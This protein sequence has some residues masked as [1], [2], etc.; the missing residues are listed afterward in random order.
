MIKSEIK[1]LPKSKIELSISVSWDGWKENIDEAVKKISQEIKIPGF[2][3]GKAPRKLIEEKVGSNVV[4]DEAAQLTIAKTY[5]EVLKKDKIEAIGQPKAEILKVAPENDFEYK[6]VTAVMPEAEVKNW[7]DKIKKVNKAGAKEKIEV[8][9]E[10]IQKELEQLAQSRVQLV[11]VSREA[12]KED[13][14]TVDFQVKREGVPIEGGSSKNHSLILG[15]GVF[16]PGFEE[17]L[18]GMKAGEE[19]SFELKFPDQYHEKSLAGKPAQFEVKLIEVQER[20]KPEINDAFAAS[21]GKFENLDK[22]KESLEEG[23]KK[24]K[25]KEV[26]EKKK[27]QQVEKLIESTKAELPEILVEEELQRMLGEFEMQLSPMGVN[28]ETYLDQLKKTKEDLEKDWRPQA[29]KRIL[30][31]LALEEVAKE[32]EIKIDSKLIEAEMNK[33]LAQYKNVKDIEKKLDLAKVYDF[34]KGNLQNE[35][36]FVKLAELV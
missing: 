14:V 7:R 11:V 30:A 21:L 6:I 24:E 26:K 12:K 18:I 5:P 35:E 36:V 33:T 34:V 16:I 29:E 8:D 2:R 23:I 1:K 20:K 3:S 32:L 28:L 19:K 15:R 10:E 31:A 25:E 13:S 27:A 9:Q 17:N 4:L 22:L